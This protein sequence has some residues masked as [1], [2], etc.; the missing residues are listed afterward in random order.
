[1]EYGKRICQQQHLLPETD[2]HRAHVTEIALLF[3]DQSVA[4]PL[5][6]NYGQ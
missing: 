6:E 5:H 3:L 2:L 4:D 1:M